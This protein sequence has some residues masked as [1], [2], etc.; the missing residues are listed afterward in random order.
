M[1]CWYGEFE[2]FLEGR[3]IHRTGFTITPEEIHN[4]IT[5]HIESSP[6]NGWQD[7]GPTLGALRGLPTLR[8]ANQLEVKT[9]LESILTTKFGS[10]ESAKPV[11]AAKVWLT[12][13]SMVPYIYQSS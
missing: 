3:S 12:Q 9:A 11:K 13:N 1:W 2:H 8:W 5:R 10:K 6:L 7:L 4:E